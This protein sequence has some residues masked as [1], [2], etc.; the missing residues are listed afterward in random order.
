MR[1]L[2]NIA[3][4][5]LGI[6][7]NED[8]ALKRFYPLI[9]MKE[10]LVQRLLDAGISDKYAFL[11]RAGQ[12][13][14][15]A[16]ELKLDM[17]VVELLERFLHLHD[18]VNRR[19]KDV[20][21]VSAAFRERLAGDGVKTSGDYLLLCRSSTPKKLSAAYGT[22]EEEARKLFCLCDLM[23]L[24]GVKDIRASLYYDC[25]YPDLAAFSR[26]SGEGMQRQIARYIAENQV[27]KSV[28]FP[29]ELNTQ[30]AAAK[31][32][33]HLELPEFAVLR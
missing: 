3:V 32:L 2:D 25:G 24:P 11:E 7:L 29:K 8:T 15:L 18:F 14:Q 26:Q 16:A 13:P 33:P 30:I 27:K 20:E 23:R 12:L 19:L 31:A 9:P 28:P 17:E 22:E 10:T 5:S 6:L 21:S 1:E 4:A